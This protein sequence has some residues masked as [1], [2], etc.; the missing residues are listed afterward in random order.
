M[1]TVDDSTTVAKRYELI[2]RSQCDILGDDDEALVQLLNSGKEISVLWGTATTG[3]PHVAYFVLAT[4]IADLLRAGCR[5]VVLFADLHA[6]LD[7]AE[8]EWEERLTY[9]LKYYETVIRTLLQQFDAPQQKL[10]F[11][12]GRD[13]QLTDS[14]VTDFY[15]LSKSVTQRDAK[16]AGSE[17]VKKN[18]S[19]TLAGLLY[20]CL[21]ALDEKHLSVDCHLG[22][23][24][25][26]KAFTF[27][28]KYLPKIGCRKKI[29]LMT[30]MVQG[31]TGDKMS[32]SAEMTKVNLLDDRATVFKRIDKAY[33]A[34]GNVDRNGVLGIA[35]HIIFPNLQDGR[36]IVEKSCGDCVTFVDFPSLQSAF[37][38][39]DLHPK[40]LKTAVS[41]ELDRLLDPIRKQLDTPKM[42]NLAHGA[43][44]TLV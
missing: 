8:L 21:Q 14:Y 35:E 42:Q 7:E 26:R 40:D 39:R 3:K 28:E 29:H 13:Y 16:K 2:F 12:H 44:S 25:Q 18:A 37:K 31:L 19:P 23:V 4:K 5:V 24:D 30:P 10:E 6:F 41:V 1:T 17:V 43:Y 9:R 20:P 22:G 36:F 11:V 27:A 32:S 38:N 15:K 34:P 33:C